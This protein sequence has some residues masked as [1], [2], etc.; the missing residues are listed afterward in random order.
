MIVNNDNEVK[1]FYRFIEFTS[2]MLKLDLPHERIKMICLDQYKAESK[3]E[4]SLKS[5]SDAYLYLNNNINQLFSKAIISKSYYLL[6]NEILE[7]EKINEILETYYKYYDE[8]DFYVMALMH[9]KILELVTTRKFEFAFMITNYI[10]LKRNKKTVIPYPYMYQS[11][12]N[13]IKNKQIQ[14]LMLIFKDIEVPNDIVLNTYF[15]KKDLLNEILKIKDV[16]INRFNISKMYLYGSFAKE[17]TLKTSDLDLLVIFNDK[18]VNFEKKAKKQEL[19]EYLNQK[20]N[21]KIDLID[22]T[23]AIEKLDLNEM[24]NII[25]II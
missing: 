10:M 3:M 21:I 14:K 13:T 20:L 11:Y 6:A 15:S 16:L 19:A 22:F 9:L 4:L 25:T 7:N 2:K 24:E 18:I 23:S 17:K 5:F 8:E 12:F 1:W